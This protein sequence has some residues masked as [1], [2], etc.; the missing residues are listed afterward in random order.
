MLFD[1][2]VCPYVGACSLH[3]RIYNRSASQYCII[4]SYFSG[5]GGAIGPICVSFCVRTINLNEVPFDR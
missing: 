4:T 5:P 3:D 2:T 1:L